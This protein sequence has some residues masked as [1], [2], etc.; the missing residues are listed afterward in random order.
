MGRDQQAQTLL[1]AVE[2][3]FTRPAWGAT[4]ARGE[5]SAD[6]KFQFTRPAWGATHGLDSAPVVVSF[7]SRA[8]HGARL[9]HPHLSWPSRMFQFT[10]PA[11]GATPDTS[12]A[13]DGFRFQF[14]RP[15][16]GATHGV[17]RRANNLMVSIHAPRMGRDF[18]ELSRRIATWFQFT[19]PAWG[20]T[21]RADCD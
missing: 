14:T 11:W 4:V 7:N 8:P 20:A 2:F 12:V 18:F 21:A 5:K 16:W 3:Q 13:A 15:A 1:N 17:S 19:R 6:S 10:R 9:L